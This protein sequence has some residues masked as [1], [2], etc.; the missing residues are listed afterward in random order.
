MSFSEGEPVAQA[1]LTAT[2]DSGLFGGVFVSSL[3]DHAVGGSVE[4]DLFAGIARTIAPGITADAA[5]YYYIFPDP[6]PAF[7]A[8]DSFEVAAHLTGTLGPFTPKVGVW[9]SWKQAAMGGRENLYLFGDLVW[10]APRVP[11]DVK[12]HLGHTQGVLS[13]AANSSTLDW[14]VGVGFRPVP[15]VRIGLE[16]SGMDG[17]SVKDFTDDALVA[18]LSVDF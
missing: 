14:S 2:H 10:T 17:P 8:T 1:T 12:L 4:V 6:N 11:V 3:A 9:Y 16:Y 15:A 13:I 18:S 7:P 5:L